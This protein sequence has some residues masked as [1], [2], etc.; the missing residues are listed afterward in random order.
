MSSSSHQPG[1]VYICEKENTVL[2]EK[3][4]ALESASYV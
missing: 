4:I 3:Y 2:Q 1:G